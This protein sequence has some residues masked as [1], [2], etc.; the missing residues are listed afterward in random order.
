MARRWFWAEKLRMP[1]HSAP[2]RPFATCWVHDQSSGSDFSNQYAIAAHPPSPGRGAAPRWPPGVQWVGVRH[3]GVL[4]D[5]GQ[6][7]VTEAIAD[8]LQRERRVDLH[9]LGRVVL[10]DGRRAVAGGI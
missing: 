4:A 9:R 6:E 8:H 2:S 1:V 7:L 3:K 10:D 5:A